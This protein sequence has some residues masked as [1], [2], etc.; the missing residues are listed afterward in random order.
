MKTFKILSILIILVFV[1]ISTKTREEKS[2]KETNKV[3][4]TI[5]PQALLK[6]KKWNIMGKS[7]DIYFQYTNNEEILYV[8]GKAIERAKY[9]ISNTNCFGKSYN[10]N[11]I[12]QINSGRFLV[13]EDACYY[14]TILDNNTIQVS[15][16]S[17][18]NPQT[19]TLIAKP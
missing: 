16:L 18:E 9:Y 12:G 17:K 7:V 14:L 2:T 4:T 8:E 19:T 5:T 10:S 1:T 3:L 11:K 15:Y 13:T 6:S